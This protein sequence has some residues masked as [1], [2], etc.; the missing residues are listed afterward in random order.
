[1]KISTLD[2]SRWPSAAGGEIEQQGHCFS[3]ALDHHR[4]WPQ[5][6]VA[7]VHPEFRAFE[8]APAGRE[9]QRDLDG[10]VS[11]KPCRLTGESDPEA[12]HAR[13]ECDRSPKVSFRRH[14]VA[15]DRWVSRSARSRERVAPASRCN[16]HVPA[17][18]QIRERCDQKKR[19]D[20]HDD[21]R[22]IATGPH[23]HP[24]CGLNADDRERQGHHG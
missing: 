17:S 5:P 1:M 21:D 23:E 10:M 6:V 22:R 7:L 11:V 3:E 12:R 2:D 9:G 18:R 15:R 4:L 13:G 20:H 24:G 19:R 14:F 8:I 16:S